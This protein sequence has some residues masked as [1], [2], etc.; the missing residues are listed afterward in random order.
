VLIPQKYSIEFITSDD[1][2]KKAIGRS[3]N[4]GYIE[5]RPVLVGVP[6]GTTQAASDDRFKVTS[7]DMVKVYS[8]GF[9][10]H[11]AD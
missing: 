6:S 9:K 3:G 1:D 2:T 5:G 7:G 11:G 4:H 10:V 8:D